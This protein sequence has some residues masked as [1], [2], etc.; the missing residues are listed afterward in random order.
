MNLE[1]L[2][3]PRLIIHVVVRPCELVEAALD[4]KAGSPAGRALMVVAF[5]LMHL[6]GDPDD[7][8]EERIATIAP[9]FDVLLD[10]EASRASEDVRT[11]WIYVVDVFEPGSAVREMLVDAVS[12]RARD[13]YM[14]VVEELSAEGTGPS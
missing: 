1:A 9:L 2:S 14:A 10:Q 5:T 7:R 13:V 11:L 6:Y 4:S 3:Y 12:P 8:T